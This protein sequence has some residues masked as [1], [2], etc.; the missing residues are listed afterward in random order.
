MLIT[1][2]CGTRERQSRSPAHLSTPSP[3]AQVCRTKPEIVA[4]KKNYTK[5]EFIC[6]LLL[7]YLDLAL[8]MSQYTCLFPVQH[9]VKH[10]SEIHLV[11]LLIQHFII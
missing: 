9:Y 10:F 11:P 7:N 3:S 4:Q 2:L 1:F 6:L 5:H 8:N